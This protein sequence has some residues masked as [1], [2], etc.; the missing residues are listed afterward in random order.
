MNKPVAILILLL[1]LIRGASPALVET[2]PVSAEPVGTPVLIWDDALVH[3]EVQMASTK[4]GDTGLLSEE[5]LAEEGEANKGPTAEEQVLEED[6]GLSLAVVN[7]VPLDASAEEVKD[8]AGKPIAVLEDRV[9]PDSEEW[10]Y[11]NMTIGFYDSEVEYIIIPAD[12]S[13]FQVGEFRFH[14]DYDE[15]RAAFGEP[16]FVAED[17]IVYVRGNH[18]MKLMISEQTQV[19]T[20]VHFYWS[21]SS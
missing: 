15:L 2:R 12:I 21:H 9:L 18:C 16:D 10:F 5:E 20:A 1:G 8:L 13:E 3:G 4:D 11:P 14:V 7:G 6:F 17:G 19:M